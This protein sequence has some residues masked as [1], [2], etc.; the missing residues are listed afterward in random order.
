MKNLTITL[1][2]LLVISVIAYQYSTHNTISQQIQENP[3]VNAEKN[4]N[5][6][7]SKIYNVNLS[8]LNTTQVT[9]TWNTADTVIGQIAY[10]DNPTHLNNLSSTETDPTKR[11]SI[12]LLE[13]KPQTQYYYK[14]KIETPDNTLI[15]SETLSFT[16][17]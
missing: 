17:K 3:T 8:L 12:N 13:L 15:E 2:V 14:I 16:T 7:T 9:I 11:H 5:L 10:G 4:P 1:A 6:T